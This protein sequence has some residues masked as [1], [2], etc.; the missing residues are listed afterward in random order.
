VAKNK[1]KQPGKIYPFNIDLFNK[2]TREDQIAYKKSHSNKSK[3][4]KINY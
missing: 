3:K 4:R 2:L 1:K